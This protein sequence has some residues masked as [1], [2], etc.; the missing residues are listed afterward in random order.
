M[1]K[2]FSGM[3]ET[4]DKYGLSRFTPTVPGLA[5][6]KASMRRSKNPKDWKGPMTSH[7]PMRSSINLE[8][9]YASIAIASMPRGIPMAP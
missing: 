3:D 2:K 1:V 5:S 7:S 6:S 4:A 9:A 8:H